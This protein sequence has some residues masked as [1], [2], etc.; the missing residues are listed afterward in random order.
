MVVFYGLIGVTF[1]QAR[2][3]LIEEPRSASGSAQLQRIETAHHLLGDL[4]SLASSAELNPIT[5]GRAALRDLA[6]TVPYAA[7]SVSIIDDSE[8]I[9]VATR[10]QPG[11]VD[12]ARAFPITMNRNRVGSLALWQL[13]EQSFDPYASDIARNMQGVALSFANVLLLQSIA[14]RVVREERVRLARELH[15]D[16]GPSLV[17]VG[18]GLDLTLHTGDLDHESRRHLESMRETVGELVEE[19]RDT[20]THLRSD[21]TSSLLEHA[22]SLAADTPASGPSFLVDIDEIEAP[23]PREAGELAAIM[24]EAVRNA[25]EHSEATVIRIEGIVQRDRGEFCVCDNGR[26]INPDLDVNRRYGVIGMQER[27]ETIGA[28]LSI[29]SARGSGTKVLMRWGSP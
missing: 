13:D 2:R 5:I 25:V 23:R 15:D 17:S 14:H 18:L 29:E 1:S 7:G 22:H 8:E 12:D 21:D 10:G 19:V 24:T 6:A 4:A 11:S 3:I 16:I 27:A 26:G 20:V 28:H 9:V